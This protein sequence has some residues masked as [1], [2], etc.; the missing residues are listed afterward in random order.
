M[1]KPH[2]GRRPQQIV[3]AQPRGRQPVW[4]IVDHK[5]LGFAH[6]RRDLRFSTV[7]RRLLS[8]S[9]VTSGFH[10]APHVFVKTN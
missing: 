8:Y 10:T 5:W 6:F 7:A 4:L 1:L 2:S 9:L 3:D